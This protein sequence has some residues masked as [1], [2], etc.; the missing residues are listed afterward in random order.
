M[1]KSPEKNLG[2]SVVLVLSAAN[3][4]LILK[5]PDWVSWAPSKWGLPGGKIEEGETP[6]EAA[7]RE[8]LEETTLSIQNLKDVGLPL[9][10]GL[11]SFYTSAY[12]GQVQIDYEHEDWAW[13]SRA[14]IKNY[15]LAPNLLSMYD[16]VLKYG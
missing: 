5:R 1:R 3:E 6:M 4:L 2:G 10:K 8:A 12:M 13:V 7:I 9:D 16:W 14:Q 11:Y 15:S